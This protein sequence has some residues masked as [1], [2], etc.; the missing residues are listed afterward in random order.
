MEFAGETRSDARMASEGPA[1]REHRDREV[2]PT[3]RHRDLEVSPTRRALSSER[4]AHRQV[5]IFHRSAGPVTAALS[6]L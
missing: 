1:L 2:S 6:E 5:P 3:G 4:A